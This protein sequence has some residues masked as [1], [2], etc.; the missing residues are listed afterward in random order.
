LSD[1]L[2]A[3]LAPLGIHVSSVQ[4]GYFRTDFLDSSSLAVSPAPIDDYAATA[5]KVRVAARNLNH[6]QPG[7]PERL[8]GAILALVDAPN[9]PVRLPLGTDTLAAIEQRLTAVAQETEQWREI[10]SSTDL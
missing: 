9:P 5:G 1:A 8:A 3:E 2:H 6:N 10:A 4:P 7:D